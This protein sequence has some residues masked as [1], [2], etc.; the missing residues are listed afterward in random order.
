MSKSEKK[1]HNAFE[2]RVY[3]RSLQVSFKDYQATDGCYK[4]CRGK[5]TVAEHWGKTKA[6]LLWPYSKKERFGKHY[7]RAID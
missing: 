6:L 2:M 4:K 3:R 1:N 5:I 7:H